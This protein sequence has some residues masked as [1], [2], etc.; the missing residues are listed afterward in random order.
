MS[1]SISLKKHF[2]ELRAA[3]QRALIIK[4]HA[5]SEALQLASQLQSVKDNQTDSALAS[6]IT[7]F[8]NALKPIQEYIVS[9]QAAFSALSSAKTSR[10]L[11]AAGVMQLVVSL[12]TLA[13]VVTLIVTNVH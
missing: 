5:D 8:E 2:D 3:D 6:A 9:S 7:R 4:Q 1:K 10:R 12:S 11:D 13:S